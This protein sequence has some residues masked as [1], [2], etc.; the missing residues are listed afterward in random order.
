MINTLANCWFRPNELNYRINA[1]QRGHGSLNS[2]TD[3]WHE[4]KW[5]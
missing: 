1:K 2:R 3:K 4:I 5:I